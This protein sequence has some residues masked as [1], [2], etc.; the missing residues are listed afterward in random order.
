[1]YSSALPFA[2]LDG[3]SSAETWA[4]IVIRREIDD[5]VAALDSA[6]AALAALTADVRW[7]ADGVRA[8]HGLLDDMGTRVA[9][10]CASL[11]LRAAEMEALP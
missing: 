4:R 2:L 3:W 8:L 11:R 7:H 5:A 6:S 10:V 9:G 1:M